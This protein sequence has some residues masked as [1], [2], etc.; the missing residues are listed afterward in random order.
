MNIFLMILATWRISSLLTFEDGPFDI[1]LNFREKLGIF[2]ILD[3]DGN[4]I[5]EVPLRFVPQMFGCIWCISIWVGAV[6]FLLPP[7]LAYSIAF[8][9]ALSTGAILIDNHIHKD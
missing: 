2:D 9:F 3:K 8:P 7:H 5:T 6:F 4:T 1:F